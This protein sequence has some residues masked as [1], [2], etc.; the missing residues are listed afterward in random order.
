[1][2]IKKRIEFITI[3]LILLP[4]LSYYFLSLFE[5]E[6]KMYSDLHFYYV[7]FSS[8]IA[9]LVGVASFIEFKKS[10]VEKIFYISIGFFGV[11]IL[12]AFHALVTPKMSF[13]NIFEFPSMLSNINT[14]VLFGDMSRFWLAIMMFM[15]ENLFEKQNHIIRKFNVYFISIFMIIMI[16]LS[17][18]SLLNPNLLPAF[19]NDDFSDTNLAIL[20]K[21]ITLLFLGINALRYFY[22]YKAKQN[23][24]IISFVIGLVLIMETVVIFMISKP[25]STVWWLAHNVFLLSYL[26]IGSG[27]LYSYFDKE[28]YEYFDVLGQI[29]KY[30][31]LL[32]EKNIELNQLANFDPLTGL[33]NRSNFLCAAEEYLNNSI[34]NNTK[35]SI[36]FIDLDDFKSINDI[37]GHQVGDELLKI[38]SKRIK[39]IVKNSDLVARIGGDEFLILLKEVDIDQITSISTRIIKCISESIL[40]NH[41]DCKIGASIG[42]SIFPEDGNTLFS[43][44]AKS[45]ETM[46]KNKKRRKIIPFTE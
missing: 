37:Y 42:V 1:M 24:T 33:S 27:V 32:E 6:S 31:K 8:I 22:S 40:I 9:I 5:S 45:D 46:Y 19:K 12:Y 29:N 43:L 39:S 38:V 36:M 3:S 14:F 34:I 35:F 20:T 16:G 41:I 26:V 18:L 25:W 10:R 17:Y 4:I 30:T 21:V 11:G 15:P 2:L 7:I 23:I 44:I 13:G 28:K